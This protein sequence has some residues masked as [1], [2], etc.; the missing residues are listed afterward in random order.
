VK[1]SSRPT[2]GSL[3]P[4]DTEFDLELVSYKLQ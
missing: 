1:Y 4:I 2:F 3:P